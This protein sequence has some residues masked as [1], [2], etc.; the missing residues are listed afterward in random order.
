MPVLW[1]ATIITEFGANIATQVGN[2]HEENPGVDLNNR[3]FTGQNALAQADQSVDLLNNEIGR[4]IGAANPGASP[5]ELAKMVLTAFKNEGLFTATVN[6]DGS[7]TIARTTITEEQNKQGGKT[8][9]SLNDSGR[10]QAEQKVKDEEEN[11]Q[12]EQNQAKFGG[13]K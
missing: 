7:V 13:L 3:H 5:K 4:G 10:T 12:H 11:K 1:Q 2:A 9:S 8:I 6:A